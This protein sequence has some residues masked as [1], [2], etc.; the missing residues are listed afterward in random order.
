M[1][2]FI[3]HSTEDDTFVKRLRESLE[4]RGLN[5]WT[6]S[7][8]LSGGDEL[9]PVI[10]E[11]IE[12]AQSFIVI[13]SSNV[14]ASS[15]V[16]DE[17]R[18]ALSIKEQR[19]D[20]YRVIPV[21]LDGMNKNSLKYFFDEEPA[22]VHVSSQPGG[23]NKTMPDLLVAL[24]HRL[25]NDQI[26]DLKIDNKPIEELTL[27]LTDPF[28][29]KKGKTIRAAATAHLKYKPASGAPDVESERFTFISPVGPIEHEDL[30]WYLEEY[31]LWPSGVFQNRAE[32]IEQKFP[33][34]GHDLYTAFAHNE[35]MTH[36]KN[37]SPDTNLRFTVFVDPSAFDPRLSKKKAKARKLEADEASTLILG[38]PWELL[39]D[40]KAYLFKGA[41]PVFVR[42]RLPN[43]NKLEVVT[44]E[45]PVRIL[46]VSP[47]PEEKGIGYIDHRISAIPLVEAME[48][49]GDMV[50]LTILSP[51]TFGAMDEELRRARERKEPYHVVHFDGHGVYDKMKGLGAL[52]FEKP[53]QNH[54]LEQ[55]KTD[56]INAKELADTIQNHRI[57]LF[58]LEACQSAQAEDDPTASVAA[59]LLDQGVASIIAM[60]HSVLVETAQRFVGAFYGA[61]VTGSPVGEAVVKARVHLKND[62]RRGSVFGAGPLHLED[63]FVPVLFQEQDDV[64]LFK[65]FPSDRVHAVNREKLNAKMGK[66]P[67]TPAHSFV[68]RSRLLLAIERKL[69]AA[70][71]AV[72]HGQGGEGKTT[73]AVELARWFVR[74]SQ[75]DRAVFVTVE[76]YHDLA[77][78]MD[79]IGSQLVP[80]YS[81]GTFKSDELLTQGFK[82]IERALEDFRVI[83][84]IDNMET[85][86]PS[87]AP[88]Y[89]P[90]VLENLIPLFTKILTSAHTRVL[91]TTR[92]PLPV[93]FD[94]NTFFISH[95]HQSE[96]I[97]LVQHVMAA[98]NQV[99][100]EEDHQEKPELEAL[101]QAVNCHARSLA[102]LGPALSQFGVGKTTERLTDL[103][104]DMDI[105][106]PGS[107]E[108]SLVA[109]VELSLRRLK[110]DIREKLRALAVFHGGFHPYVLGIT[111]QIGQDEAEALAVELIRI[112][113]AQA[114]EYAYVSIHPALGPYLDQEL[115]PEQ[116]QSFRDLWA[117]GMKQFSRFLY[118]Q[119]DQDTRVQAVLT[120]LDLPNL[121]ALLDFVTEQGDAEET[122][123]FAGRLE[124]LLSNLGRPHIMARVSRVRQRE[125]K[126][127]KKMSQWSNAVFNA[128]GRHIDW[129][130]ERRAFHEAYQKAEGLLKK[131][132][133]AGIR[134]YPGADYDTAIAYSLLGS[135][136]KRGSAS[137]AALGYIEEAY[138]RFHVLGEKGNE[139]A[140][141]M[142]SGSLGEKGDCLMFLGRLDESA[143][144]Y[145]EGISIA[146][147][148]N[149]IRHAAAG[150]GSL[151]TVRMYQGRF[152]EAI[153][154]H[155]AA[156]KAFEVLQD[157]ERMAV[158]HHQI[159]MVYEESGN[160]DR[161]EASYKKSLA[162]EV[163]QK[164]EAGQAATLGQLG[165]LYR[166]M[167]RFEEAAV[168]YSQAVDIDF[169]L[170]DMVN[171]GRD[172]SNLADTLIK[173]KRYEEARKELQRAIECKEPYGHAAEPWKTYAH[174]QDL[175]TAEGNREVAAQAR[176]K[177]MELYL[178]YRRAGGE[179]HSGGRRLCTMFRQAVTKN[180]GDEFKAVLDEVAEHPQV[181][182]S[183]RKLARVLSEI[184]SGVRDRAV[185]EDMEL[186]YDHAAEVLL[187][188]EELEG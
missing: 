31:F 121:M 163:Q 51:P 39:H 86:L 109:S 67:D 40:G 50:K 75:C 91:F 76:H 161:A 126:K 73:L 128:A 42:R 104:K 9:K 179:N 96:A 156:L 135:V 186:S 170:N 188:L 149:N 10:F 6:D 118:K 184:L 25:P 66:L 55:R 105:R 114:K 1:H 136:L 162:L 141:S 185:V 44:T 125:A 17:T 178:S 69:A 154:A 134:A 41:R 155:E 27:E 35:A 166:M 123:S 65:R 127:L 164:D 22:A 83:I 157:P 28:L 98:E 7:R 77:A 143:A 79:S 38:L 97:K 175:E 101:V 169:K 116:R 151:G 53:G 32:Q 78:V 46:L 106:F 82:E 113:L 81:A 54:L 180:K 24:G 61:V 147:S 172:R 137:E 85:I 16:L 89:D 150:Q 95:L 2:I 174:L 130:L 33:Q 144:A 124:D 34:W 84:I 93:P 14:L 23:I 115:E 107:R 120:L 133:A 52:C 129:L 100:Y 21:L 58:F 92:V 132:L 87:D 152:Q 4:V 146:E 74:S 173:L 99:P 47:R 70:P 182:V 90:I 29:K 122:V 43:R 108:Q 59:R 8:Y 64:Q 110:P 26:P 183:G 145:E 30:R 12:T 167:G 177:A 5:V 71:Y 80:H 56:I 88:D 158:A 187:I 142:A 138:Q 103:M 131:S 171:E 15:W 37:S 45:L 148:L 3:S 18:H 36:W 20:D 48:N 94:R 140:A 72:L 176:N 19:K 168:F 181:D 119:K 68:G 57:P 11:A 139:S 102:L 159:G 49:L 112:G 62:T 111:L 117:E 165:K 160:F 13:I 63:W 153:E 60:S